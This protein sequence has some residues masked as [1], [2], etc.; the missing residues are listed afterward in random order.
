MG[1]LEIPDSLAATVALLD[2]AAN[3]SVS[4]RRIRWQSMERVLRILR[5]SYKQ[6]DG[7]ILAERELDIAMRSWSWAR[8][9][10]DGPVAPSHPSTGIDDLLREIDD[11]IAVLGS[12]RLSSLRV[13]IEA[14]SA[15]PHPA[16]E[17]LAS[18]VTMAT[19]AST[20]T[21][22]L[23]FIVRG[24]G[25]VGTLDW[26]AEVGLPVDVVTVSAA[27]RAAP[28][29]EAILF[30]P[31]E[32]YAESPWL[33]GAHASATAGWLLTAPLAPVVTVLSWTGHRPMSR[34]G[35]QPWRGAPSPAVKEEQSVDVV[36]EDFMPQS[37]D[38]FR[39]ISHPV[40]EANEDSEDAFAVQFL[41]GSDTVVAYFHQEVGPKPAVLTFEDGHAVVARMG[42]STLRM[43][44]A[45]LLRTS[46]AGRDAL[47][48][49]TI[50]WL[51]Q[52]RP[53][54]SIEAAES[55]QQSLKD[56]IFARSRTASRKD[57]V[58]AM[59]AQGLDRSY[60]LMLP[61][62]MRYPDFIAPQQQDTY[63]RVCRAL[64]LQPPTNA[65]TL[66]KTLRTARRQAGLVLSS[67]IAQRLDAIPDLA[68]Q[69]RDTG[70][71]V[72]TDPGVEGVALLVVRA[73]GHEPVSVPSWRL[74]LPMT[75]DGHLWHT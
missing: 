34:D 44:R 50:E 21:Q 19:A 67:R 56:A 1:V 28:W 17:L 55:A 14:I 9:C 24:E 10:M 68:D 43:G 54:F 42:L 69:L 58:D 29:S 20:T 73:V 7:A 48:R 74:G 57:I 32:R 64:D 38:T 35:Y 46:V 47:D 12:P 61:S 6:T 13:A 15:S 49:A 26:V 66:L 8:V 31:P 16:A 39:P 75:P 72:L 30:G 37:L 11:A 33:V 63:L 18:H 3:P 70:S 45:V 65:F 5:S 41:A 40:F 23:A 53:K 22:R 2:A 60:A 71:V 52:N 27:R 51:K 59:V 4:N 62:R 25:L 36:E